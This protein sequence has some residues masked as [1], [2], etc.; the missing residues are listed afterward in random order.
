METQ[1]ARKNVELR[2]IH[3]SDVTKW[4]GEAV[5]TDQSSWY[6]ST[7]SNLLAQN[8]GII[9][10]FPT[11]VPLWVWRE[12]ELGVYEDRSTLRPDL[13]IESATDIWVIEVKYP[14]SQS[15]IFGTGSKDDYTIAD[16]LAD[17]GKRIDKLGWWRN[18]RKNLVAVWVYEEATRKRRDVAEEHRLKV[19]KYLRN[20]PH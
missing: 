20:T 8:P 5:G 16:Q 17:Y 11:P 1:W 6:E 9:C 7:T 18:K 19:D 15:D 12:Q 10:G 13:V 3:A 2:S 4:F 14:V